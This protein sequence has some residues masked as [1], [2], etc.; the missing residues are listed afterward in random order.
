MRVFHQNP[1][2]RVKIRGHP[3]STTRPHRHALPLTGPLQPER[4]LQVQPRRGLLR[5]RPHQQQQHVG[6]QRGQRLGMCCVGCR[7]VAAPLRA[8]G[9]H[10]RGYG[11]LEGSRVQRVVLRGPALQARRCEVDRLV[12]GEEEDAGGWWCS[13]SS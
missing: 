6:G 3:T 11:C 8:I 13:A 4:R 1:S 2:Y 12:A 9:K 10:Q 5:Q 7:L